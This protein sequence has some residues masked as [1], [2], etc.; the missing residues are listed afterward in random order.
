VCHTKCCE[1]AENVLCSS[2]DGVPLK[3]QS[4]GWRPE[5]YLLRIELYHF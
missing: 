5:G 4:E 2:R 3:W 1:D